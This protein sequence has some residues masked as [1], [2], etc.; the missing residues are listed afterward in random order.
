MS[1]AFTVATALRVFWENLNTIWDASQEVHEILTS[2][3]IE[4]YEERNSLR[5][6]RRHNKEFG[7]RHNNKGRV[8][9]KLDDSTIRSMQ[10]SIRHLIRRF[11]TL[12]KPFLAENTATGRRRRSSYT[13][14]DEKDVRGKDDDDDNLDPYQYCN[15][16]LGKRFVWLRTRSKAVGL[17]DS[18]SRVQTRRIARQVGEI[19]VALWEYG[20]DVDGLRDGLDDIQG[21]LNRVVGVRR[22]D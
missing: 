22:V 12:E 7:H 6:L 5:Q 13:W 17:M 21:R 18:L 8:P 14:D 20:G 2:L 11:K 10:E 19:S 16:T 1:F 3:R 4:L 15:M 9:L